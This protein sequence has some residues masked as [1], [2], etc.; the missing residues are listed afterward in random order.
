MVER[1]KTFRKY[2]K[3]PV[4]VGRQHKPPGLVDGTG[5]RDL[6]KDKSC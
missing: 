2:A 4:V 5:V 6:N 3:N 1:V